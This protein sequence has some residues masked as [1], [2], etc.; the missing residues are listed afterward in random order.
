[1]TEVVEFLEKNKKTFNKDSVLD[2]KNAIHIVEN[3]KSIVKSE[4]FQSTRVGLTLKGDE[5]ERYRFIFK[6]YRFMIWPNKI[7]KGKA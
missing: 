2:P 6:D 5:E 1:M 4:I 7:K 3:D